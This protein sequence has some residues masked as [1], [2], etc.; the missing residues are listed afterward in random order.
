VTLALAGGKT[1]ADLFP[2][3][4]PLAWE[5]SPAL[6]NPAT[7]T[8]AVDSVAIDPSAVQATAGS[9]T[10]S[11][12]PSLS[13][14]CGIVINVT[15]ADN[16]GAT[17]TWEDKLWFGSGVMDVTVL[18][19]DS[20]PAAG[21]S[22]HCN[23]AAHYVTGAAAVTDA[24]GHAT[25][26]NL[27]G[28][29]IVISAT[30]ADSGSS[31]YDFP[32][33]PGVPSITI[34]LQAPLAPSNIPNNDFSLGLAGWEISAPLSANVELHVEFDD[35]AIISSLQAPQP[36]AKPALTTA[37]VA[38]RQAAAKKAVMS[39]LSAVKDEPAANNRSAAG[40]R[41]LL[42]VVRL[43]ALAACSTGQARWYIACRSLCTQHA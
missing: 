16:T 37:A 4:A 11:V 17:V 40:D 12:G 32:V 38:E 3:D 2:M 13:C 1:S 14:A 23:V 35:A 18:L 27:P 9:I 24:S 19:P 34:T 31:L 33:T 10:A 25:F 5:A 26:N 15:A 28:N 39:K 36:K 29:S 6:L 41:R 30:A 22:V 8:V 20:A 7:V 43:L 42:Q 21:A